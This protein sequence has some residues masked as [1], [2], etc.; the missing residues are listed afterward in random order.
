MHNSLVQ[1]L[2]PSYMPG[3]GSLDN[4]RILL[5]KR[6]R[7]SR[8]PRLSPGQGRFRRLAGCR[9]VVPEAQEVPEEPDVV[10]HLQKAPLLMKK[11]ISRHILGVFPCASRLCRMA[12]MPRECLRR[13]ITM[14][15][16]SL[17]CRAPGASH[18]AAPEAA[19][20]HPTSLHDL[21]SFLSKRCKR[22]MN[23]LRK[24]QWQESCTKWQC[25][26]LNAMDP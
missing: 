1:N 4:A 19:A 5:A 20:T 26:N 2:D 11:R 6:L 16:E 25:L 22:S 17:R 7:S 10:L 18:P 23:Q 12:M 15:T 3:P 13:A 9:D 21:L 24:A 14:L 8:F